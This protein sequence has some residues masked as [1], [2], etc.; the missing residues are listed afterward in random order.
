MQVRLLQAGSQWVVWIASDPN[1]EYPFDRFLRE[2]DPRAR[3]KIVSDLEDY[4]PNSPSAEWAASGFSKRLVGPN[5]VLEF[6]WSKGRGGTPRLL[7]FFADERRVVLANGFIKKGGMP[8]AEVRRAEK[9][10]ASFAAADTA[11]TLVEER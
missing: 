2:L 9:T 7:W 11:G 3:A 1:G 6:R 8:P 5:A 4:V 10:L